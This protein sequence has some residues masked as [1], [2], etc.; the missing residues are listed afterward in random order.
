MEGSELLAS[1]VFY[2]ERSAHA[3]AKTE[4]K[5]RKV[6]GVSGKTERIEVVASQIETKWVTIPCWV[7]IRRKVGTEAS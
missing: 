2:T 5:R 1:T 7:L 3:H 4:R 6:R